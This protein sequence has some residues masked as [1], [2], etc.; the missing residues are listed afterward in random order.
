M[1][2]TGRRGWVGI[3]RHW[4][5]NP[6]L[7]DSALRLML[8]LDSHTD[9]YLANLSARRI[10]D[11]MGWSRSRVTRTLDSL[12]ELGLLTT[13]QVPHPEG[14]K[15]RT[16]VTLH[17]DAWSDTYATPQDQRMQH[18]EAQ[19]MQHGEA[20]TTSTTSSE[21]SNVEPPTPTAEP[22]KEV[23]TQTS[24]APT[25]LDEFDALFEAFW[26]SYPNKQKKPDAKKALKAAL[27]TTDR[28]VISAGLRAWKEHWEISSLGIP[29][30]ATWLRAEQYNDTP[31]QIRRQDTKHTRSIAVLDNARREAQAS[32]TIGAMFDQPAIESSS[33]ES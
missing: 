22:T 26:K 9:D 14:G 30:P 1:A 16:L 5:A 11:E 3:A 33:H 24:A 29:Y 4:L 15:T 13:E 8:W 12:T 18:G 28:A 2:A 32:R 6:N 25:V 27:K 23:A 21:K 19:R 17:H 31:P 20:S 10:A 7:T